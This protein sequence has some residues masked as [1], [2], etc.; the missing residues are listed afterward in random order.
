VA[1]AS[2]DRRALIILTSVLVLA[3]GAFV[4]LSGGKKDSPSSALQPAIMPGAVTSP[5]PQPSP[6]PSPSE[7]LLFTGRDPFKNPFSGA[8]LVASSS[9]LPNSSPT[10]S[11][12]PAGSPP[13]TPTG[14]SSTTS[15]GHTVVLV[16]IFSSGTKAQVEVDGTVYTVSEGDTFASTF[17]LVSISGKCASFLNGDSSFSLCE[18]ANK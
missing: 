13:A 18:T 12:S 3:V 15:G 6:S 5:T 11:V 7:I 8:S 2:R 17:K 4:L 14:G 1:L 9:P 10:P 16:D